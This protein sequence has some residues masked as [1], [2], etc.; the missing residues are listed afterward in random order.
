MAQIAEI[1]IIPSTFTLIKISDEEYFS[2][3]YKDY[4]SN[5]RLSL[6]DPI[7]GGS[8]KNTKLDFLVDFQILMN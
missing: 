6:I 5:S 7:E 3:E 8:K 4:I 1:K 2:A